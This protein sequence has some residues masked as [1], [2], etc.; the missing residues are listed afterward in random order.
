MTVPQRP[1]QGLLGMSGPVLASSGDWLCEE[2]DVIQGPLAPLA[3]PLSALGEFVLDLAV[4]S[5]FRPVFERVFGSAAAAPVLQ[6][7]ALGSAAGNLLS[8]AGF[9]CS[10]IA[11]TRGYN[12]WHLL[13]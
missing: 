13:P 4:L 9:V 7:A 8:Q 3:T 12:S 10:L 5:V 11:A 6:L 1:P 2:D